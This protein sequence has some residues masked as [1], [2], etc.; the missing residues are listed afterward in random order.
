[1]AQ[2]FRAA[3]GLG[4]NDPTITTVDA[5]GVALAAIQGLNAKLEEK[6]QQKGTEDRGVEEVGG[7]TEGTG[8]QTDR[9]LELDWQG[10]RLTS[11][12]EL[13]R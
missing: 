10:R 6:L 9:T 12:A 7:G 5:D 11:W 4:E 1:M 2:D 3:F 8:G 13:L